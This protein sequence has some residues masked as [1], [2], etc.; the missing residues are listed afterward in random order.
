MCSEQIL[1]WI[2]KC[3]NT[4]GEACSQGLDSTHAPVFVIDVHSRQIRSLAGG[5]QF[6][7]LSY[8]WGN[9]RDCKSSSD[10]NP[11]QLPSRACHIVEDAIIVTQQ[12]G[13]QYL[14]VDRYCIAV[15]A[16]EK[17]AQIRHMSEV[18]SAAFI[19]VIALEGT[20]CEAGLPGVSKPLQRIQI[21]AKL[22]TGTLAGSKDL[23][24][25]QRSN[26]TLWKTRA[27]TLQE[28]TMSRRRLGF[29]NDMIFLEC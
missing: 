22:E 16:T 10:G 8:V 29:L 18:Y 12:L 27:W 14:W 23:D 21:G 4:H 25:I 5:E 3:A 1:G 11:Q 7:A 6:A 17:L 2:N 19:T 13:L 28:A 15:E 9:P 20:S 24:P 26:G